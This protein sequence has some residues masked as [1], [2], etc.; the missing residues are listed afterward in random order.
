MKTKR[1]TQA[2]RIAALESEVAALRATINALIARPLTP[3]PFPSYP[4]VDPWP[5][6]PTL[7][8][9]V[10]AQPSIITREFIVQ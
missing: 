9:F 3:T 2:Q 10:P 7:P 6:W 8:Y 4:P 1:L 5:Q